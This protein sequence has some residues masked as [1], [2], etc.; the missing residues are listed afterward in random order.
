MFQAK[1]HGRERA[2]PNSGHVDYNVLGKKVDV[3]V[4]GESGHW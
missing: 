4:V 3:G 2:L 1:A